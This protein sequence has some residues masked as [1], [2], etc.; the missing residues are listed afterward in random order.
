MNRNLK[1]FL[2]MIAVSEGTQDHGDDG[3]NVIVGGDLFEGYGRYRSAGDV[4]TL[5]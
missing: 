2:D 1:A 5:N 3:Y 4:G